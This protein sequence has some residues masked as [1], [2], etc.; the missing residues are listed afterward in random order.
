[1]IV[2]IVGYKNSGKDT[3]A[4]NIQL[5]TPRAVSI[6]LAD[7]M[8]EFCQKVFGFT[9][10]QLWGP[11]ELRDEPDIRYPL[12]LP[13]GWS[14]LVSQKMGGP[15]VHLLRQGREV[16]N[17]FPSDGD[18]E[19]GKRELRGATFGYLT[20]RHALQQ[21]G[22]E[23]GRK[24]YPDVWLEYGIRRAQRLLDPA[25]LGGKELVGLNDRPASLVLITDCRFANEA[26]AVHAAGGKVI[27]IT[28][29]GTSAGEHG[30]EM[31]QDDIPVDWTVHNGGSLKQLHAAVAEL[32]PVWFR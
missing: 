1:V 14:F 29:P 4:E 20:P 31:E 28:R 11:S 16:T 22:T 5:V 32:A 8:K 7:P 30:S 17:W 24:C 9:N 13:E 27:R 23:W 2:G 10:E 19:S 18:V 3:L 6:A 12:P 21:L 26:A 25:T 15:L